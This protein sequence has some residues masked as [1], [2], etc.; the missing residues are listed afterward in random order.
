MISSNLSG[1]RP[2]PDQLPYAFEWHHTKANVRA[3]LER[4]GTDVHVDWF[5][6]RRWV[7]GPRLAN[8]NGYVVGMLR[9]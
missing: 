9:V 3:M 7:F 1:D 8:G 5:P 6:I 4:H 2:G